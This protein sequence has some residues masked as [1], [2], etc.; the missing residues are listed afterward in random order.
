MREL[1]FTVNQQKL[2][3]DSTCDF[4]GIVKGTKGY[5]T[6]RFKFDSSWD[7]YGKVAVF[8]KLLDEYP[9]ILKNNRCT[10]PEKALDFDSF[11]VSV[12]GQ[13]SGGR[14]TTNALRVEQEG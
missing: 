5:L 13:K 3:K 6:A 7:G 9:V 4:S 12:I 8:K 2:E 1:V 14:L 10:I 11:S